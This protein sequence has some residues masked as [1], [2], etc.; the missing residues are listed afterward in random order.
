MLRL[1]EADK[2]QISEHK[3]LYRIAFPLNERF[4]WH[5]LVK[6]A[7]SGKAE[8]LTLDDDGILIVRVTDKDAAVN[9]P[10]VQAA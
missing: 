3:K 8:L 4:P 9:H 5:M 1:V 2:S 6:R 7:K 10:A